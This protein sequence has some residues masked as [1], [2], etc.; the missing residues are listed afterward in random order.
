MHPF[1]KKY[2]VGYQNTINLTNLCKNYKLRILRT[3]SIMLPINFNIYKHFVH[4]F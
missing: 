1:R 2:R 3:N 4:K